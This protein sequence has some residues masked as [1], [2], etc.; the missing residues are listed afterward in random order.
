V[1]PAGA[2]IV[3]CE[4]PG[5]D[6]VLLLQVKEAQRSVAHPYVHGDTAWQQMLQAVSDLLLGWRSFS[7]GSVYAT[8]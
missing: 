2:C 6:D 1:C 3:L 5:S 8:G 7:S 4:G